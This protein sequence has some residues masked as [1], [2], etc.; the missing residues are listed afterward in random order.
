MDKARTVSAVAHT[1]TKNEYTNFNIEGAYAAAIVLALVALTVL[2][3][4]NLIRRRSEL[5]GER[6]PNIEPDPGMSRGKD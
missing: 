5:A 4:M 3:A 2:V 6:E 1:L